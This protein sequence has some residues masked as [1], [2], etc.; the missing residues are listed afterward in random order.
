MKLTEVLV[1][2][3][4]GTSSFF[5]FFG[6]PDFG[7][8]G[9][10]AWFIKCEK[11][12]VCFNKKSNLLPLS[13]ATLVSKSSPFDVVSDEDSFCPNTT[14][15]CN[16]KTIRNRMYGYRPKVMDTYWVFTG[17]GYFGSLSSFRGFFWFRHLSNRSCP[18]SSNF[19]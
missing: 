19:L 18:I 10:L 14:N 15:S 7:L 13:D 5:S 1:C 17:V 4:S 8:V 12:S 9:V 16:L 11:I 6:R 2:T 3:Y